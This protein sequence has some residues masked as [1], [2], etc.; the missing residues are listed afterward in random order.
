MSINDVA[1][2]KPNLINLINEDRSPLIAC[3][4]Y[5]TSLLFQEYGRTM[6]LWKSKVLSQPSSG[7]F[8]LHS[9]FEAFADLF[10]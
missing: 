1:S 3:T 8:P 2:T 9:K 4:Q 5:L 6:L 10:Y 7:N